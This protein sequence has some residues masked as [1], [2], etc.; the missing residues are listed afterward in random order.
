MKAMGFLSLRQRSRSFKEA[1][2]H[3]RRRPRSGVLGTSVLPARASARPHSVRLLWRSAR[4]ELAPRGKAEPNTREAH[5]IG[6]KSSAKSTTQIHLSPLVFT[7]WEWLDLTLCHGR[8]PSPGSSSPGGAPGSPQRPQPAALL[9][10]R[11]PP[12]AAPAGYGSLPCSTR[13]RGSIPDGVAM[14]SLLLIQTH[15]AQG[16]TH[17][18]FARSEDCACQ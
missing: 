14:E 5:G 16:R 8:C 9:R 17:R 11:R 15:S 13:R 2:P 10:V 12:P 6:A 18:P 7:K 4:K 1:Y 3:R